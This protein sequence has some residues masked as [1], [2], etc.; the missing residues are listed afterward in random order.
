VAGRVRGAIDC[1]PVNEN[2]MELL[3]MLD[4]LKRASA[5]RITVVCRIMDT[6]ARTAKLRTVPITAKLVAI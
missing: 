4:S 3:V 1:H 6:H 5:D 2:I